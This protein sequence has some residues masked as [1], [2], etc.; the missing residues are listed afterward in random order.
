MKLTLGRHCTKQD[1][2]GLYDDINIVDRYF[3]WPN[4]LKNYQVKTV[5]YLRIRALCQEYP[6]AIIAV[7]NAFTAQLDNN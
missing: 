6:N 1:L 7:N 2:P 5:E 3:M 4:L